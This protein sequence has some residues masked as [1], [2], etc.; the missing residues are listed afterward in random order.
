MTGSSQV[1]TEEEFEDLGKMLTS[2]LSQEHPICKLEKRKS[3]SLGHTEDYPTYKEVCFSSDGLTSFQQAVHMHVLCISLKY[4]IIC[5]TQKK[6]NHNV[7]SFFSSRS[8]EDLELPAIVPPPSGMGAQPTG[9]SPAWMH[10]SKIYKKN[11]RQVVYA[12]CNECHHML[13]C[14]ST[15][16]TSHL[17]RHPCGHAQN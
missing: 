2:F 5:Y 7:I 9:R 10:F 17:M 11:P 1:Y 4:I 13:I 8:D 15:G 16:G 14:D 3:S 6:K 12:A